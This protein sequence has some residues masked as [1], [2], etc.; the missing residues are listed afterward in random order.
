[1]S[2]VT[3]SRDFTVVTMGLPVSPN[4]PITPFEG[5]VYWNTLLKVAQ[6]WN[7]KAWINFG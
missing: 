4:P 7:G 2:N 1:M 6:I 3:I 5:Q